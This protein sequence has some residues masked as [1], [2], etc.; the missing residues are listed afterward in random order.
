[1]IKMLCEEK[2][3]D[4]CF[5][6]SICLNS[7]EELMDFVRNMEEHEGHLY[8]VKNGSIYDAKSVLGMVALGIGEKFYLTRKNKWLKQIK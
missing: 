8:A 3:D 7:F 1:M 5:D 2:K 6:K 4:I